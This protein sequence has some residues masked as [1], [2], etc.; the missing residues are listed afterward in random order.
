MHMRKVLIGTLVAAAVGAALPAAAR[1]SVEF[2]VNTAPPP[3]PY[4][5]VPAPR[6]GF[7]WVPGYWDWRYNRYHW[8]AG[9]WMRHRPGY[10]YEPAR[11]I[12]RDGRYVYARP[13]WR[14]GD[15]DGDGVPNRYDARPDNPYLR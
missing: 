3:L 14:S 5:V 9:R 6:A 10:L 2:Y 4:E 12:E 7:V 15:R 13:Y 11:V 8:V 1:S